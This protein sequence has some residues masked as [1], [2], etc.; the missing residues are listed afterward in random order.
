MDHIPAVTSVCHNNRLD[1]PLYCSPVNYVEVPLGFEA[2]ERYPETCGH[3]LQTPFD[4][5]DPSTCAFLQSWLFFGLLAEAFGGH[6]TRYRHSDFVTIAESGRQNTSTKMLQKYSWYWLANRSHGNRK[7]VALHAQSLENCLRLASSAINSICKS[8]HFADSGSFLEVKALLLSLATLGEYMYSV[9]EMV[10]KYDEVQR[11]VISWHLPF[12][13][14]ALLESG[15]CKGEVVVLRRECNTTCLHFLSQIDRR[16]T[17]KDHSRCNPHDGCRALQVNEKT[18]RTL[19]RY[20]KTDTECGCKPTGPLAQD[21]AQIIEAGGIPL[22]SFCSSSN[23]RKEVSTSHYQSNRLQ[24][25]TYVAIS[26]VWSDGLGNVTGNWL[27]G[28]QLDH[29]QGL[30]NALYEPEAS[31]VPFWMDTLCVPVQSEYKHLRAKAIVQMA[32]I[33]KLAD[34]VLVLDQSL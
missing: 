26:H 17:S 25:T 2:F 8:T 14:A 30:V 16:Y 6:E 34:K 12:L 3:S 7:Q 28:C 9:R 24:R 23:S 15:W 31:P 5:T 29:T 27:N 20:R 18:Y 33:Y 21:I 4:P 13:D 1:V 32:D 11:S 10:V 22:V 19:H